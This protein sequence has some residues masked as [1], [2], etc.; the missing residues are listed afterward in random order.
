MADS[1]LSPHLR[2]HPSLQKA[3]ALSLSP[4]DPVG[5]LSLFRL[6][7]AHPEVDLKALLFQALDA[8]LWVS[9]QSVARL[10]FQGTEDDSQGLLVLGGGCLCTL[11]LRAGRPAVLAFELHGRQGLLQ[12]DDTAG[13]GIWLQPETGPA[14]NLVG[15][16]EQ[17]QPR[18][19]EE[20][21]FPSQAEVERLWDAALA[22]LADGEVWQGEEVG[23]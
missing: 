7:L 4:D 5:H 2:Y 16:S 19:E 6:R 23:L 18:P 12:Y 3:R 10:R 22:G 21:A 9:G 14:H 20:E 8:V 15:W 1:A 17:C 11:D 13:Q